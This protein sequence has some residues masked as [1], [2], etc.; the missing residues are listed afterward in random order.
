MI[1]RAQ[2]K[3]HDQRMINVYNLRID[4]I[5]LLLAKDIT[6]FMATQFQNQRKF[7]LKRLMAL[8]NTEKY[9]LETD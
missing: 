9:G 8:Y 3:E 4:Q 6:P 5:D 7:I 2:K 1:T